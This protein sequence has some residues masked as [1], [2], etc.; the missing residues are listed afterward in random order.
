MFQLSVCEGTVFPN[1]PF[2]ER[3]RAVAAAGFSVELWG[4]EDESLDAIAA[5]PKIQIASIPGWGPGSMVHTDGVETFLKGAR[6]NLLVAQRIG[7]KNLAIASGELDR[8][9][10]VIHA[11]AEHPADLW[12]TAYRCLCTLAEIAEKEDVYYNFEVL[13]TKVDHVGYPFPHLEDG[14]RLIRQVNSPRIRLLVDVY[15]V[16]VEEGNIIQAIQD[17]QKVIGH[18]HVADV[19]GR[20]EPGTGEIHYPHVVAALQ[21][22]G[23]NGTVGLE[24]FPEGDSHVALERFR[25]IFSEPGC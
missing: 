25:K 13:N 21:E 7:C 12:I 11:I 22:I 15:H 4:W 10:Q 14:A 24:A 18:V 5:D 3:V 17:H 2:R 20:H 19:P 23:Y 16:Q 9:G 1:L 6:E 8:K